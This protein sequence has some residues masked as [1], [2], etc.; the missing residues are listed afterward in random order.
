MVEPVPEVLPRIED[1]DREGD[2]GPPRKLEQVE[3]SETAVPCPFGDEER[4]RGEDEGRHRRIPHAE[5]DVPR[6]VPGPRAPALEHRQDALDQP[7][8][9][10][11][12]RGPGCL[13]GAGIVEHGS[14]AYR[15]GAIPSATLTSAAPKKPNGYRWGRVRFATFPR[16][17]AGGMENG[18]PDPSPCCS[19]SE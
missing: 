13:Q 3:Q 19:K 9:R 15:A 17:V 11:R 10:E 14:E 6:P 2:A 16:M 12:G 7:Q 1:H 8:D 18:F 5:G 4:R